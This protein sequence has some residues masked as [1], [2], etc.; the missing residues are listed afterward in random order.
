M[1]EKKAKI[2]DMVN[3]IYEQCVVD[4][5]YVIVN[6]AHSELCCERDLQRSLAAPDLTA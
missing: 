2:V 6:D 3:D 4:Y 5:L 1:E